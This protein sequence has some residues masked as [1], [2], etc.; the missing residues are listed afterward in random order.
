M[1]ALVKGLDLTTITAPQIKEMKVVEVVPTQSSF[2]PTQNSSD[3][4]SD[5]EKI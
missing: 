4:A 5:V 1:D 2:E 3:Q